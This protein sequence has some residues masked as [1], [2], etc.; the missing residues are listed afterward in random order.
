MSNGMNEQELNKI[1]SKEKIL[2]CTIMMNESRVFEYFKNKKIEDK[3]HKIY[4]C[5]KTILSLLVGIAFDKGYLHNLH[6]P[7]QEYFSKEL[8]AQ[9][10]ERKNDITLYHLLTM[11]PG[12]HFPEWEE[13]DGFAPMVQGGDIIKFT[14]DRE[15]ILPPGEKMNYNSGCSH[16]IT[17]ILQQVTGETA[18]Q[19]AQKHLFKP[20]NI[21]NVEWY[22]DNKGIYKGADGLRLTIADMEKLCLLM[23]QKGQWKGTQIVSEKWIEQAISPHYST[24]KHIGEYG[25][26][27]WTSKINPTLDDDSDSNRFHFGLGFGGQYMIIVPKFNLSVIFISELYKEPLNPLNIFKSKILEHFI[28]NEELKTAN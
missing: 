17:A 4:S 12:L 14:L 9:S 18:L 23:L 15:L 8:Q 13:W 28:H 2:A 20:L 6:Q 5:T 26:H 27:W 24:Y 11:T 19:F 3:Q 16:L 21:S 1:L 10:D 25:L 22:K 7:I